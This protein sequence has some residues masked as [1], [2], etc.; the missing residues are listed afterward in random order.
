MRI[1]TLLHLS[2]FPLTTTTRT[3][4][5]HAAIAF[6]RSTLA[7]TA[8]EA[9]PEAY[10]EFKSS[11]LA[12][13][14]CRDVSIDRDRATLTRAVISTVRSYAPDDTVIN[15]SRLSLLLRY[16]SIV[17][18]HP[19]FDF[20]IFEETDQ[21]YH[22]DATSELTKLVVSHEYVRPLEVRELPQIDPVNKEIQNLAQSLVIS[23]E[24]AITAIRL[25]KGLQNLLIL[26]HARDDDVA[27]EFRAKDQVVT[28]YDVAIYTQC[29]V[30][31]ASVSKY[32]WEY[33]NQS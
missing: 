7:P 1:D 25:S 18:R 15:D 11:M 14:D 21:R 17:S 24:D 12:I 10:S 9:Y 28:V 6:S 27:P 33:K 30:P 19:N 32:P 23:R 5:T 16:L 20:P 8:I 3:G 29:R 2:P 22:L 31:S 13:L 4:D 26:V